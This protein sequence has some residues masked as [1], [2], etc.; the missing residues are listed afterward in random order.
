MVD[1][2]GFTGL[3]HKRNLGACLFAH[4]MVVHSCQS[5]Q[6]RNGCVLFVH[7]AVGKNDDGIAGLNC[8]RCAAAETIQRA[9]EFLC[10]TL[11]PEEHG[12][13]RRKKIPL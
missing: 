6:A 10:A 4:E 2:T 7:T 13:H 3:Y 5:E 12:K 9:L 1:L 11:H 8:Q